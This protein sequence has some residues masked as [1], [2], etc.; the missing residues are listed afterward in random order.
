[1]KEENKKKYLLFCFGDV[2]L[3]YIFSHAIKEMK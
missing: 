1:M 3:L 2:E